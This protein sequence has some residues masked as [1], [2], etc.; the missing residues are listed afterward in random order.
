MKIRKLYRY[1][2]KLIVGKLNPVKYAK[3]V[4]VNMGGGY[5][6]TAQSAGAQNHGL[7]RWAIMYT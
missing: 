1:F 6:Y 2:Y 4:G 5:T 3:K 7:S